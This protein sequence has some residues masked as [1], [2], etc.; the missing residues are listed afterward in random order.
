MKNIKKQ[1]PI[2]E[3]Q[4]DLAYLDNAAT[5]QM[6][7]VVL[8]AT[9]KYNTEYRANI[10]RGTYKL[11]ELSS[12]KYE[13]ARQ[14]IAKFIN[15]EKNEI[16]FTSGTTQGLNGLANSLGRKLNSSNNIV[17]TRMEHHAN[18]IPW[19]MMSKEYGFEI[20]FIE[21][22]QNYALD[23]ESAKKVIDKNTKIVSF[24]HISNTLGTIN[25]AQEIVGLAKK[26]GAISIVDGAQ[27]VAHMKIDVKKID[28]DFFVFS[29]HKIGGPTGIGVLYG[30]MNRLEAMDPFVFGGGMI[31]EVN[32]SEA[33]WDNVPHKFEAGTPN[34][35]GAIGLG[36][37]VEFLIE[38]GMEHIEQYEKKLTDYAIAE[39][40][41][42]RQLK[43]IGPEG[44]RASVI[45]FVIEGIHPHDVATILD[46]ENVAVRAGN[47]CTEPLM[48]HLGVNGTTRASFWIYNTTDDIDKLVTGLK[49]AI[50]LFKV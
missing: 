32:Y 50:E 29:G 26:V 30:K 19:Q 47:H 15:A 27:S 39:F 3:N 37:A 13:D 28:C 10:H 5:A 23:L 20:R 4:T 12:Q 46:R 33:K 43:I 14:S 49:K 16:I 36:R 42:I 38:I 18:L 24:V 11:S 35:S 22:D 8:D 34:I 25:S 21:L 44:D 7:Q 1:F 45:S 41:K 17:L 9:T 48:E 2:F 6:P 40:S 31:A